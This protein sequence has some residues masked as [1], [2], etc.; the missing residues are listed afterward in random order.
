M[1]EKGEAHGPLARGLRET[2]SWIGS[3]GRAM[4]FEQ[5]YEHDKM[6]IDWLSFSLHLQIV[7]LL[8][9]VA[10]LQD[11]ALRYLEHLLPLSA[12]PPVAPS[13]GCIIL[14]RSFW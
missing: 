9:V 7:K 1:R 4:A 12:C 8:E 5:S 2:N 14:R 11:M 13:P 3:E 6:N 10:F